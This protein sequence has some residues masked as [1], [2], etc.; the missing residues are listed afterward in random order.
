MSVARNVTASG[1][2][3]AA[4]PPLLLTLLAVMLWRF[5][6]E[7]YGLYP[8]CPVFRY[9]HLQ[10][11]GCGTTRAFAALLHGD[12]PAA[13][14][15]NALTTLGLPFT[16]AL[17]LRSYWRYVR[18]RRPFLPPLPPAV[19]YATLAVCAVFAVARNM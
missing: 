10:C 5:P 7:R 1:F 3:R 18:L 16:L 9:L 12:I 13:L 14:R 6:P 2:A 11:P 4:M 17:A 8:P 15:L 19:L